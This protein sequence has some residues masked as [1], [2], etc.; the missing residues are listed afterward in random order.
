[1]TFFF[2]ATDFFGEQPELPA[3]PDVLLLRQIVHDWS[4]KYAVKILS[5]LKKS[6]GPNTKLLIVD[7]VVDYA[8]DS[9]SLGDLPAPP[10]VP[11]PLLPNLGAANL[12]TYSVDL[13]VSMFRS[14]H[15]HST[16]PS[17][18]Y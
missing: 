4:D 8:C 1:M 5:Q 15:K 12:L 9:S 2:P 6:A 17:L 7:C 3:T 16:D 10:P 14:L 13:V 11:A 18:L